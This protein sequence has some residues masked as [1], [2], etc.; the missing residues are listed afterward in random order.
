MSVKNNNLPDQNGFFGK[1]G[2]KFVPETL[3]YALEQLE[4][5]YNKLKDSEDFK[6]QFYKSYKLKVTCIYNPFDKK[7]VNKKLKKKININFYKKN[8]LNILTVGRLTDQKDHLTILKA[9]KNLKSSFKVRLII[10]GDGFKKNELSNYITDNNIQD[11]IRLAGYKK[12]PFPYIVRS[13]MIILSSLYEGLPNIL[14][15]AQ[16]LKKYIIQMN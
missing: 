8:Y 9:I 13:D 2:G 11:K 7:F 5:T 6:K 14:L 10:V 4:E 12:N 3:M 15:E 1:Y 16:Y